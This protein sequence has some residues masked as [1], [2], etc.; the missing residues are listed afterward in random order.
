MIARAVSALFAAI[1][2]TALPSSP[3]LS[4]TTARASNA[5]RSGRNDAA[6]RA[7]S[8]GGALR[9]DRRCDIDG[10][11][12]RPANRHFSQSRHR[13]ADR[14]CHPADRPLLHAGPVCGWVSRCR[15]PAWLRWHVQHAREPARQAD[16]PPSSDGRS[17]RGGGLRGSVSGQFQ[18][19]RSTRSVHATRTR[20]D[21]HPGQPA[22][23]C[24]WR[25][26]VLALTTGHRD[27][28]RCAAGLVA[29][30]ECRARVD[31]RP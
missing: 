13:S 4:S 3:A 22:P 15:R 17:A 27:E 8:S 26:R 19:T 11:Q 24:A 16:C 31:E 1:T 10:E 5:G 29:R 12:R 23:R 14:R 9:D 18:S 30:R 25:A 7:R 21:H 20:P 6:G 2:G 28:S